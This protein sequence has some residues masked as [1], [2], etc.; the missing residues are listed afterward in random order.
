MY[1]IINSLTY[2]SSYKPV[3]HF[4]ATVITKQ[5]GMNPLILSAIVQQTDWVFLLQI[6]MFYHKNY[7]RDSLDFGMM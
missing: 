4:C 6:G 3:C 5:S 2:I 1:F 7:E